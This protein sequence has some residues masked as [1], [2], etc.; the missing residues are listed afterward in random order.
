MTPMTEDMNSTIG[1]EYNIQNL[2]IHVTAG[3]TFAAGIMINTFIVA[4]YVTDWMKQRPMASTDQILTS[5]GITRFLYESTSLLDIFLHNFFEIN[6]G[7][8]LTVFC[9]FATSFYANIWLANL[10]SVV[11]CLKICN[12]QDVF[13]LRLK[14]MILQRVVHLIIACVLVSICYSLTFLFITTTGVLRNSSNKTN[15]WERD[16]IEKYMFLW[17]NVVPFLIV[18]I[19]SV[20]LISSLC[21]HVNIMRCD[22]AVTGQL[23]T[24]YKT[25]KF[26]A[27]SFLSYTFYFI[28][29]VTL[30]FYQGSFDDLG[31]NLILSVFPT[32]HSVY[33]IYVTARLRT[34]FCKILQHASKFRL[35]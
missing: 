4:V 29:H 12:F 5:L 28:T 15:N 34:Q 17:W 2:A 20:L 32:L 18:F 11:F 22:R 6:I 13:F 16:E 9:I 26:S 8:E 31:E 27:F 24:Y 35:N 23:D 30:W 7:Y 14:I 19:S 3:I 33:L 1:E 25:I 10:L 21:H